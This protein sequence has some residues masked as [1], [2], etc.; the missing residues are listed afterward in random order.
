MSLTLETPPSTSR[1][2]QAPPIPALVV[3][4]P[5][6][7]RII[8]SII[9]HAC[10]LALALLFLTPFV[11]LVCASFRR[12]EDFFNFSFLPSPLNRLTLSNYTW[13]FTHEPFLRWM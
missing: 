5:S 13:L 2:R 7:G 6:L 9:L 12:Q 8:R 4:G 3:P 10:I 11:W 1:T